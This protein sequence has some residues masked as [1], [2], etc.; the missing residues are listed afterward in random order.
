MMISIVECK[1]QHLPLLNNSTI[2]TINQSSYNTML[3]VQSFRKLRRIHYSCIN[4][5]VPYKITRWAITACFA[6]AYAEN[7][8]SICSDL[9]TYLIAFYLL[10]LAVNYFIPRGVSEDVDSS[11]E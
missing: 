11:F 6:L 3:A 7:T 10:I 4:K 8:Q 5:I 1:Y 9:V 2:I